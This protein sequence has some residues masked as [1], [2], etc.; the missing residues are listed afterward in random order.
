MKHSL[1][2]LIIITLLFA[3][4]RQKAQSN[5]LSESSAQTEE[6]NPSLEEY[7]EEAVITGKVLNRDFYPQEKE[8][9]LI[10]PFFRDMG[11]QY[12]SPIQK[13]GSFSFR[14][15]V[16][17]K[18]REVSIR[19][20]AEH[21]YIHPGDSIH[22][23]IDFKDL[24]HPKVTGDAEKLNQEILAFTES[25][26]YYIQNYNMK[27]ESDVKD[28][29]AELKKDYNFRLERRNEYLVKYKP[30][31]DVVLFTEELLKQDYYYALLFN[32]MSYL[33][34]TRKEMDRYHTLL[35][36][37]NKLY[38]K[39]ILSAR[40]YDV[41]DEAERYIADGIAFRDKKNP[42]IEEI[43]ATMGESETNLY[44]YTKLIAGSLCTNDTLAFH[45]KRTQFDSIVKISH[46]RAQVMQIYNQTKSYLKNPQPVSDNLLYGE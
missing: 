41:A 23:E 38:T 20:Y 30:M 39:G 4:C 12:R 13:D 44:L 34:K 31:E 40:L 46:L 32:G 1:Y 26:Y 24:F 25:A 18:L 35:P 33:F 3:G 45:E 22:V 17:A 37:I 27:P 14:F 7:S 15:P 19:N 42:S 9:T 6:S 28:F 43:M 11:N 29:E 8:L 16:Y 36:E 10:I 2:F 21:L 5:F